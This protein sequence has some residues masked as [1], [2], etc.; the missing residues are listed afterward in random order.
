MAAA[1][2]DPHA[3]KIYTDGSALK[4]P[5]GPGGIAGVAEYPDRLNRENETIFSRGDKSTTNNRMEVR[6][7]IEALVYIGHQARALG[8]SRAILITDSIYVYENAKRAPYWREGDR[9]TDAGRPVE[10]ADLWRRFLRERARARAG[11]RVD[12]AW[13]RGKSTPV[14]REVD[15]A[16]KRAAKRPTD[17]DV[18][19]VPG[20]VAR[21]KTPGRDAATPFPAGGQ[22]AIIRIYR[23]QP[24]KAS[25][26]WMNKVRCL[27]LRWDFQV[28]WGPPRRPGA[29]WHGRPAGVRASRRRLLPAD[30]ASAGRAQGRGRGARPE[31]PGIAVRAMR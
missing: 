26:S 28:R 15:R 5:G 23:I 20:S 9:T 1:S 18:G 27:A 16:A 22:A 13:I 12:L 30:G 14:T 8:I 6:A 2:F 21:R 4:N 19:Y 7:C 10:N 24:R 25:G 29:Q 17:S 3:L 31:S 11:V